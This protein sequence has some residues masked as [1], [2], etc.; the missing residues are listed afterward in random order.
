[1]GMFW[2][3]GYELSLARQP[4]DASARV[5]DTL[6]AVCVRAIYGQPAV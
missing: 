2:R 6:T 4:A 5:V 1:M 3:A